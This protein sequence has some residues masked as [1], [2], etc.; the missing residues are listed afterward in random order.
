MPAERRT[1]IDILLGAEREHADSRARLESLV[2]DGVHRV[3]RQVAQLRG[4]RGV[5]IRTG[6]AMAQGLKPEI[7]P[8][9]LRRLLPEFLVALEPLHRAYRTARGAGFEAFLAEHEREAAA[10]LLEVADRHIAQSR[11]PALKPIYARFRSGAETEVRTF[12]PVLA[13]LIAERLPAR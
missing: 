11:T 2:A 13:A 7:L 12:L 9:A 1:L 5:G 8:I 6:L 4:F 3:E 10:A